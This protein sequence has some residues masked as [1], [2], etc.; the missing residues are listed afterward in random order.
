MPTAHADRPANKAEIHRPLALTTPRLRGPDVRALQGSINKGFDHFK[1]ERAVTKD[2]LLG[3]HTLDA[4]HDLATCVGVVGKGQDKLNNRHLISEGVQ[5]LIRGRDL[6]DEEKAAQKKRDDYR[7]KLRKRY[8]VDAG[9]KAIRDSAFLLG[10]PPCHEEPDGSNWGDGCQ[11]LIEFTGYDE[12]VYWCGCAAAFIVIK[13]GG[14]KIPV[15]IRLGYAGYIV[16]D[17]LNHNNGLVAT[18]VHSARPGDVGSLWGFEHIVTVRAPVKPGDTMVKTR[19]GNTSPT[20]A[21]SQNNGGVVADKE[22]PI[23]DFDRGIVA[24][25]PWS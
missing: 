25:P 21:G 1:I 14:A 7:K 4:A 12:P 19:E 2:G 6:T 16:E 10:P 11:K 15:P 13:I 18:S 3:P 20:S 22:R 17:A 9:E 8:A 23:S 24:R 5:A